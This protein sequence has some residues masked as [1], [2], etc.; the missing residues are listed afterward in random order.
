MLHLLSKS[1]RDKRACRMCDR[2]FLKC[3]WNGQS[4]MDESFWTARR[5]NLGNGISFLYLFFLSCDILKKEIARWQHIGSPLLMLIEEDRVPR[6]MRFFHLGIRN[7][8]IDL[9]SPFLMHRMIIN[10]LLKEMHYYILY[11]K[12]GCGNY[13]CKDY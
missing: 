13:A 2:P 11:V 9:Q 8:N 1:N 12:K 4:L 6:G 7:R 3:T 5:R 10:I